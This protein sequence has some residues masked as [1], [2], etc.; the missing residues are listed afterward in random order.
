LKT[1]T[2]FGSI[3]NMNGIVGR[4]A[5]LWAVATLFMLPAFAMGHIISDNSFTNVNWSEGFAQQ[6]FS[7][8]IYPRWLPDMSAG[9]GSPVFYFYGPLPFYLTAP[10]HLIAGPRLAVLL[11]MWLMLALSGHAFQAL[12]ADFVGATAALI[13]SLAYMAMPYHFLVDIW[14]RS[15]F[16]ELGAYIFIPL[17]LLCVFRL[18]SGP[19]WTFALTASLAGLLLSHLP[20]ALLFAPFLTVF[21]LYAAT[22]GDFAT[23]IARA[24]TAAALSLGVAAAYIVPALLLQN[25]IHA[26]N[27]DTYLPA[28]NLLFARHNLAFELFLDA[29]AVVA[30]TNGAIIVT[31]A[32]QRNRWHSFAPWAIF[33]A[34][35]LILTLPVSADLWDLLPKAFNKIQFAWRALILLD[36]ATCMLLALA[37]DL[38]SATRAVFGRIVLF[39]FSAVGA[40]FLIY[41]NRSGHDGFLRR[42]AEAENKLIIARVEPLEYLPSCRPF[43]RGDLSDGTSA[44]IVQDVIAKRAPN[45]LAVFHYPFL[46]LRSNGKPLPTQCDPKTGFIVVGDHR[47]PWVIETRWLPA[48]RTGNLLS[49]ASLIIVLLGLI[50]STKVRAPSIEARRSA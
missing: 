3:D 50:F 1:F 31:T 36:V 33:A 8:H 19:A 2:R 12:A 35:A 39:T 49:L 26:A 43:Q 7:G 14:L 5:I 47:G 37:F 10:F 17:C 4:N 46:D 30:F 41:A 34:A 23:T 22:R 28:Q 48:E 11:G 13:A 40:L 15:D 20:S 25:L 24:A 18:T 6:L 32:I 45:E 29:I 27:W 21:C 44:L 9:T 38:N 16:G 42:T